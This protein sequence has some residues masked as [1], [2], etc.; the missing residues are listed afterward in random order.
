MYTLPL[1][2]I[3]VSF[4]PARHLNKGKVTSTNKTKKIDL[5]VRKIQE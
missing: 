1:A 4:G 2:M 3:G 5:M